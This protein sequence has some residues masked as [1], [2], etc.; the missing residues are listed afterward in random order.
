MQHNNR[1]VPT[2]NLQ[3]WIDAG[4]SYVRPDL[5][6]ANHTVIE[7]RDKGEPAHPSTSFT[8]RPFGAPL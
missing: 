1:S 8:D 6:I 5:M 4:W 7:W 3:G 2:A